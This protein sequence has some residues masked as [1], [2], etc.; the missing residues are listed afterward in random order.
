MAMAKG[1][2]RVV[3]EIDPT[4][5]VRR[6]NGLRLICERAGNEHGAR[7]WAVAIREYKKRHG[8]T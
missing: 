8:L 4:E 1:K 3:T 6:M 7:R 5:E 2:F